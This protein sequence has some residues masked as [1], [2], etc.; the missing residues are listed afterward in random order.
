MYI[1]E[2]YYMYR[3]AYHLTQHDTYE[4][5]HLNPKTDEV[6][7]GKFGRKKTNVIRLIHKG[8]DWKNHLKVDIAT[9]FQRIKAMDR[10]LLGRKV[11]IYNV[12]V[13]SH[14][15]VDEWEMYKR[16][17]HVE[18]KKGLRMHVFYMVEETRQ[19]EKE[20]LFSHIGAKTYDDMVLPT[21]EDQEIAV[22]E[23]KLALRDQLHKRNEEIRDIFTYGKPIF[24]YLLIGINIAL[25]LLLEMA[26]GST[27]IPTLIA[28]GAKFNPLIILGE[29]WR[30]IT[31]MFLHIGL[32][33][34]FMNMLALYY[35][36]TV[37]E[38]IYGSMRFFIIY[39]LAGIGGG[40]TSFAFN[41]SV[42]AGASGALFGLFGALLFFGVNYKRLFL[43]T[44]G[45]NLI[46]I[47]VINLVIGF[48][49]PQ[50]D[51][52]AHVG[53]LVTGFVAAAITSLPK[54]QHFA[55]QLL[56]L[57]LY[58]GI[59]TSLIVYGIYRNISLLGS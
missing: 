11:D 32:V 47:L 34:L 10:L 12:Y 40:L 45:S 25:F 48:M 35:L 41:D 37:V 6:W 2:Q 44:M 51:M 46:L 42:A 13:T 58:V 7:L 29:W 59:C 43:Q 26:G 3:M 31:S 57:L 20:R 39:F 18:N 24:T 33:H 56:S 36:G 50:I 27:D 53:G 5:L 30:I 22:T 14:E 54:K 8:F 1:T 49:I 23:Y 4:V 16:P 15:P 52:G 21:E 28:F 9:L 38:R 55:I 17:I 19:S